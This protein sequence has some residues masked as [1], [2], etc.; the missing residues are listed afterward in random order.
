MSSCGQI[1]H[2]QS[3]E[4]SKTIHIFAPR[5]KEYLHFLFVAHIIYIKKLITITIMKK[6]LFYFATTIFMSLA[7]V[8]LTA[9]GDDDEN[10]KGGSGTSGGGGGKALTTAGVLDKNSGLRVKSINYTVF[11]YNADG[12]L[13]GITTG[14][15]DKKTFSY[16]PNYIIDNEGAKNPVDYNSSGYLAG[17]KRSGEFYEDSEDNNWTET[18]TCTFT[19]DASGHLTKI[20]YEN[21]IARDVY[22]EKY[23]D[24]ENRVTTL[25]WSNNLLLKV[26]IT[27]TGVFY[28]TNYTDT[29]DYE[30]T[31]DNDQYVNKY[32]QWDRRLCV[33]KE[34]FVA[35]LAYVGLLGVGPAKLPS[36]VKSTTKRQ[37]DLKPYE[38]AY[39]VSYEFNSDGSIHGDFTYEYVK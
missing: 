33:I 30:F 23:N 24:N 21:K 4:I 37:S 17:F 15:Y 32:F 16:N 9:C 14:D 26:S 27:E 13:A 1:S 20:N 2:A 12:T 38:N 5:L 28:G 7:A 19:Y 36:R 6:N 22:G 29:Y 25:T 39:G 10:D 35:D 31:Y 11:T 34:D 18:E 3:Q 8:S